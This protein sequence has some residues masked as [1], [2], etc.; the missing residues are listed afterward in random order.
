MNIAVVGAGGFARE[1]R[2][3]IEDM[4]RAG[5]SVRFAGYV[6]SDRARLIADRDSVDDVIAE[7]ADLEAGV[8][9]VDGLALGIGSP[10]VRARI[11]GD[12]VKSLPGVAWPAL[13]HPSAQGDFDTWSLGRG[14]LV[15]AGVVG[16]VNI[17]LSDFSMVN[18]NSTLGH[19]TPVGYGAVVN[20]VVSV[21]GGVDIGDRSLIGTGA[22]ILQYVS[23]GE[24]AIVGA[25]AVVVRDVEPG[26]TVIGMPARP[27]GAQ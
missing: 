20:P 26:V 19:E 25:G 13:V 18:I 27:I 14:S 5:S 1:V 22:T 4:S 10:E 24:D 11:G 6:V 17:D 7:I 3:L 15:C 23:I 2:W 9:S 21:S 16:T 8:V 12:L